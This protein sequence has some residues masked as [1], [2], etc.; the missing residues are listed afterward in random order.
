MNATPPHPPSLRWPPPGLERV[1]GDL[2]RM[3]A[4]GGLAGGLL[5]L[6]MLFVVA[7][8][9]SF[10]TLG[11]FADAWWVSLVLSMVGLGFALDAI[12]TAT[13][14]LRRASRVMERGYDL[15]TVFHVA[16]DLR[17]DMG[18]LLQGA[19]HFS[20]MEPREREAVATLRVLTA[21]F[22][23]TAGLWLP[24]ALGAGLLLASRA[25]LGH[26]GLWALTLLP[27]L[28]LYLVGAL[29]SAVEG[30]RVRRARFAWFR[31]PWTQDLV[32]DEISDWR[33][34]LAALRGE[35]LPA[36]T[37]GGSAVLVRRSA[38]V[39][40]LLAILVAV[41]VLTLIPTSAVG[42]VLATVALP[43]FQ[44]IQIRAARVEAYREFRVAPDFAVSPE[45]AGALLQDL[46]YVDQPAQPL[47]GELGPTHTFDDAWLP[48]MSE[49]N[50]VGSQAHRWSETIFEKTV[51]D[52]SPELLAFLEGIAKHPAQV[53]FARLASAPS[54]DAASGRW[55]QPFPADFTMATVPIPRLSSLREAGYARLAA[56]ALDL[57]RHDPASAEQK[58]REVI[59]VGFLLGDD[60][61]TLIDNLVGNVVASTGATALEHLYRVTGRADEA[62]RV[63][64]L[65]AIAERAARRVHTPEL[66]GL[67]GVLR[68]LP[69]TVTDTSAVRGLRWEFYSLTTTL[70]PCINLNRMVFGPGDGY[71]SFIERAHASLVRYPS[72]EGLFQLA[73][74]GYWGAAPANE[75]LLGRLLSVSM[76]HG[77]DS[78]ANVMKRFDTLKEIL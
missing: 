7:R 78:C 42:P 13:R 11:P 50:P 69:A 24:V 2:W 23:A 62:D 59:S 75:S 12:A 41:P 31:Q 57:A 33:A 72:E 36:A 56:A 18:F 25:G 54:L 74:T 6:P 46:L 15:R 17:R 14:I 77:D 51:D 58:V 61:P 60:G 48:Q 52:P 65:G 40:G 20:L 76:R 29:F 16:A 68:Y 37:D 66:S 63:A 28:A 45:E 67:E 1:Q 26:T 49:S 8:E 39:V 27:A 71:R 10:S 70:T 32:E 21:G 19:K 30:S 35:E 3:A 5:V 55:R 64:E 22:Y 43:R 9:Q 34:E 4:R 73:R 44:R 47:E 38:L 53:E